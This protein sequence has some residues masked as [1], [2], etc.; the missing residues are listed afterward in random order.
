[1]GFTSASGSTP[2]AV[3]VA[4]TGEPFPWVLTGESLTKTGATTMW[5]ALRT[6]RPQWLR[7]RARSDVYVFVQGIPYGPVRALQLLNVRDVRRV[8]FLDALAATS[9]YGGGRV[10]LVE[11]H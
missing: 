10:L 3:A 8:E 2:D 4:P 9:L 1:M 5:D 11:L 6:L 7:A